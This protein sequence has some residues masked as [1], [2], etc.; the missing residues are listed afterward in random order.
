MDNFISLTPSLYFSCSLVFEAFFLKLVFCFFFFF[1][2]LCSSHLAVSK[3]GQFFH[4]LY[5]SCFLNVTDDCVVFRASYP[6]CQ[7]VKAVM[8]PQAAGVTLQYCLWENTA[9]S[10]ELLFKKRS[11]GL[12][13][14]DIVVCHSIS[15]IEGG[16]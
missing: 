15:P 8:P 16:S 3:F 1:F 14:G 9:F 4:A 6:S 12:T 11:S 7:N 13:M 2:W 10:S 5:K